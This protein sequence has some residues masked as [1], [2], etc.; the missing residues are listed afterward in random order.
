LRTASKA[1]TPIEVRPNRERDAVEADCLL[2]DF[3]FERQSVFRA[4]HKFVVK[5]S[6]RKHADRR[7]S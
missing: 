4:F 6:G 1:D 5:D 2:R 7:D 3:F